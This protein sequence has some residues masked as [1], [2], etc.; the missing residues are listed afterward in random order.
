MAT[1][2]RRTAPTVYDRLYIGGERVEGH[3]TPIVVLDPATEDEV[4]RMPSATPRQVEDAVAAA[5]RASD[6]GPWPQ[7]SPQERSAALHRYA[8]AFEAR[9][10]ELVATV[11]TEVGTPL[12]IAEPLQVGS[13]LIHL[14]HYADLAGRDLFRDLGAGTN[15]PSHSE[16]AYRPAGVA[17]GITAYNFPLMLAASKVG[18]AMAAGCTTVLL[19]SPR[20]PLTA[21]ILGELAIEAELPPGV[22]NVIVGGADIGALLTQHPK[23]DRVSF[24]GSV[25]VGQAIMRQCVENVT[26][27]VL[28]LGGKSPDIVLDS[29]PLDDES[30]AGIHMRYLRNAGQGCASPTRILV[31]ETRYDEFLEVT[32]RVYGT[33]PVGDPWDPRTICG[34]VIRPEHRDRVEGF[35]ERAVA[36]GGRIVAGGGRP[37]FER[38]WYVN[39]TLVGDVDPTAEIAQEEI[40]GPVGVL[41]PYR[42]L[43][44]AVRIANSTKFGLAAYVH[45]ASPD[46]GRALAP[47]LRAGTVYIN[48]GGGLRPD[49]PFGG[50]GASSIGREWGAEGVREYLE[51]QHIQ[52]RTA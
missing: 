17:A 42:D 10:P 21:L 7:L 16:L 14:R 32:R 22:L 51:P 4:A 25:E 12:A 43:D 5:R 23:V 2:T 9:I 34:P 50:W 33:V 38:G 46:E 35:V 39:P 19:P 47:R 37:D 26:G 20:T 3:G 28:E 30:V 52:W 44:D 45:G 49:A 13:A 18:A 41:L 8:D 27:V 36:A 31:S 40:F 6:E 15:P 48:G 11:I 29:Y 1:T 24:T